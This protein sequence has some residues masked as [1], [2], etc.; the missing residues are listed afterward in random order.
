MSQESHVVT[1][2]M[3]VASCSGFNRLVK[4]SDSQSCP[5]CR[6]RIDP[7]YLNNLNI[8]DIAPNNSAI[9]ENGNPLP[10]LPLLQLA[11]PIAERP[12]DKR[13]FIQILDA[14]CQLISRLL[15]AFVRLLNSRFLQEIL[16][17]SKKLLKKNEV[18]YVWFIFKHPE[19]T[20]EKLLNRFPAISLLNDYVPQKRLLALLID[21]NY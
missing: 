12:S 6:A 18:K 14:E 9:T 19:C 5:N 7:D 20:K 11:L 16:R 15:S 4:Q 10:Q 17:G 3:K 21:L 13:A 1:D 8:D 2:T